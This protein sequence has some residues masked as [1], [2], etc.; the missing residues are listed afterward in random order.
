[1]I[2]NSAV[3]RL[4]ETAHNLFDVMTQFCLVAPRG[5]LCT[6]A[7]GDLWANPSGTWQAYLAARE[8]FQFLGAADRIGNASSNRSSFLGFRLARVPVREQDK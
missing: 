8:A 1:M 3:M 7:L 2:S 6:E 4:T 5:L